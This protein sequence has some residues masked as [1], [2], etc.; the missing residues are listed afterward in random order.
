MLASFFERNLQNGKLLTL[1]SC[2][3]TEIN[4]GKIQ[5]KLYL[6]VLVTLLGVENPVFENIF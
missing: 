3:R 6:S 1:K 2:Y 5:E 4:A